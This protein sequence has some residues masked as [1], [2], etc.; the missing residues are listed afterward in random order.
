L[1]AFRPVRQVPVHRQLH[2]Q[3]RLF[4]VRA[5]FCPALAPSCANPFAAFAVLQHAPLVLASSFR[6]HVPLPS[7]S[8]CL[9][10]GVVQVMTQ[11]V[12]TSIEYAL[13]VIKKTIMDLWASTLEYFR[14]MLNETWTNTTQMFE[15]FDK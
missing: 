11:K 7:P 12:I 2:C 10:T 9:S 14:E 3:H 1:I 6:V 13:S 15:D 4:S 8:H 5:L